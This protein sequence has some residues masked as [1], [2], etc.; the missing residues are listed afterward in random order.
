MDSGKIVEEGTH[1]ELI[2]LEGNYHKLIALQGFSKDETAESVSP[3][4][5]S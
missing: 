1:Q 5:Q 4:V 3:V 2:Q